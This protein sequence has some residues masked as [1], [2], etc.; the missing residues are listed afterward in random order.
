MLS[1]EKNSGINAECSKIQYDH[2]EREK[3]QSN[4]QSDG[5]MHRQNANQ[6]K[7]SGLFYPNEKWITNFKEAD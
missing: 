6:P 4:C 5:D 2:D 7:E 3:I 1:E